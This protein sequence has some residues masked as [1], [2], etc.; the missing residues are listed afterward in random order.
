M[1]RAILRLVM[2]IATI[3]VSQCCLAAALPILTPIDQSNFSGS[4]VVVTFSNSTALLD[5]FTV[6]GVTFTNLSGDGYILVQTGGLDSLFDNIPGAS[7]GSYG[8][9]TAA[10]TVPTRL[11]I[12]LPIPVRRF[13]MLLTSGVASAW[14]LT[15]FTE[16]ATELGSITATMPGSSNAVFA[17]LLSTS[18]FDQV[19]VT[20]VS[21]NGQNDGFDDI[22][23]ELVPEPSTCMLALSLLVVLVR[24][25]SISRAE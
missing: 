13:G 12:D 1:I 6:D 24:R 2:A 10:A 25:G 8:R 17:G 21:P 20:E 5:S 7:L 4:E 11:L 22:R 9:T 19:L 3:V 14:S 18:P 23:F 16:D 15:A